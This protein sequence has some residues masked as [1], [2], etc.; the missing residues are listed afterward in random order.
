MKWW[1]GSGPIKQVA[2]V[3]LLLAVGYLL[4]A[5]SSH[6]HHH[7]NT[8]TVYNRGYQAGGSCWSQQNTVEAKID[9]SSEFFFKVMSWCVEI[10]PILMPKFSNI[11]YY[12]CNNFIVNFKS[13]S[14]SKHHKTIIFQKNFIFES[15]VMLEW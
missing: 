4:P 6:H 14:N 1:Y 8:T 9:E 12:V 5:L 11:E 10:L 7:S 13:Q 3:V 15:E 2:N